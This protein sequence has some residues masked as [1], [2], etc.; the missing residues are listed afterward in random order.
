MGYALISPPVFSYFLLFSYGVFPV[1]APSLRVLFQVSLDLYYSKHLKRLA[2][3][4]ATDQFFEFVLAH[5]YHMDHGA[6]CKVYTRQVV[7]RL[8]LKLGV[9]I[10]PGL[11]ALGSHPGWVLGAASME[12]RFEFDLIGVRVPV[13]RWFA[14]EQKLAKSALHFDLQHCLMLKVLKA[15]MKADLIL[16]LDR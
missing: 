9:G 12:L 6:R 15:L 2:K 8:G 7:E 13:L 10:P 4:M 5:Q 1:Q 11:E 3:L 14:S 16:D